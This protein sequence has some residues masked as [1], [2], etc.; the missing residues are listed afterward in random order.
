MY[1]L[2]LRQL[3][4]EKKV[5][6]FDP[7]RKS[8]LFHKIVNLP[9]NGIGSIVTMT[10]WAVKAHLKPRLIMIRGARFHKVKA[11]SDCFQ[12]LFMAEEGS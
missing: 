5:I 2:A 9:S 7:E 10:K 12:K 6:P 8:T 4:K 11:I 1:S 3:I